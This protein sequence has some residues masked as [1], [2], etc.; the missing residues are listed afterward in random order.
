MSKLSFSEVPADSQAWEEIESISQTTPTSTLLQVPL[1]MGEG[2]VNGK[3]K[4]LRLLA[5][6][7][8]DLETPG[9][10]GPSSLSR[11]LLVRN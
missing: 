6:R 3:Q 2:N 9:P 1:I 8:P 4:E 5:S 7:V 11:P 10:Q